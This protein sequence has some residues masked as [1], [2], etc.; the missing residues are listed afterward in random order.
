MARKP[1]PVKIL[2]PHSFRQTLSR[3]SV[4]QMGGAAAGLGILGVACGGSDEGGDGD[5]RSVV[6]VVVGVLIR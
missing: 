1:E 4:L 2:A 3:R 5:G 6:A